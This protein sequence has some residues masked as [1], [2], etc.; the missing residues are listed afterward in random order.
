MAERKSNFKTGEFLRYKGRP[1]VRSGYVELPVCAAQGERILK[2]TKKHPAYK[3]A[4]KSQVG[5]GWEE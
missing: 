5:D 1:L 4:R 2:V 3:R